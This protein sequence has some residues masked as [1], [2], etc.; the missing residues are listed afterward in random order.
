MLKTSDLVGVSVRISD[1]S[2]KDGQ[3]VPALPIPAPLVI[4]FKDALLVLTGKAQAIQVG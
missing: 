1:G 3:W 4:R 2:F